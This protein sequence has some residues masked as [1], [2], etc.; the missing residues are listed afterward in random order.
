MIIAHLPY[1][2]SDK[3]QYKQVISYASF[4]YLLTA[5]RQCSITKPMSAF[6]ARLLGYALFFTSKSD[7]AIIFTKKAVAP[8][9]L[10]SNK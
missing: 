8:P 9:Q 7:H 1:I 3:C 2:T 4:S 5:T 6:F 10:Q